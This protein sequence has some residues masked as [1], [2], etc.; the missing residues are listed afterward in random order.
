[1]RE[2]TGGTLLMQFVIVILFVFV[3]FITSVIQYARVYRIKGTI[4]DALERAEGGVKSIDELNAVMHEAK[5]DGKY[6][7]CKHYDSTRKGTYYTVE[8][9]SYFTILPRFVDLQLPV[10]GETRTIDTGIFFDNSDNDI[11]GDGSPACV[12]KG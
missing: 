2:A 12:T 9:Y 7:I 5:Y 3:F 10:R 11:F 8:I 6:K 1:M 4:V